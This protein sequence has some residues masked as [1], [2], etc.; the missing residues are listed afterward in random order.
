MAVHAV[1]KCRAAQRL[2]GH[3]RKFPRGSG[4]VLDST[5]LVGNNHDASKP[6]QRIGGR[7][8]LA[9]RA[10][11]ELVGIWDGACGERVVN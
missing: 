1:H 5:D 2:I 7:F 4:V 10:L 9:L 11:V 3:R 6:I 8:F